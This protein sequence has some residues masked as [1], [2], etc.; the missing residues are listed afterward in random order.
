MKGHGRKRRLV[1]EEQCM[2]YIPLLESL[3]ALLQND[4]I[5]AEVGMEQ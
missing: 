2:V 1:E 5:L 4:A 3:E